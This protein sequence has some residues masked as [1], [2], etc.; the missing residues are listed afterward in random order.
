[1]SFQ[2]SREM[3]QIFPQAA[4]MSPTPS[5]LEEADRRL[6]QSRRP[7]PILPLPPPAPMCVPLLSVTSPALLPSGTQVRSLGMVAL[8]FW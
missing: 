5:A 3:K 8:V 1:M 6:P 2:L 7:P 4:L